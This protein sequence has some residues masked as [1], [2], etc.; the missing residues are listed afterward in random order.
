MPLLDES[1][2]TKGRAYTELSPVVA[3][4]MP[5]MID[6]DEKQDSDSEV[7]EDD[8][9]HVEGNPSTC[10]CSSSSTSESESCFSTSSI[11]T[12]IP[13]ATTGGNSV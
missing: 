8:H 5:V 1:W 13:F 3:K 12:G 10:I 4:G 9:M 11:I 2:M 7:G 6:D